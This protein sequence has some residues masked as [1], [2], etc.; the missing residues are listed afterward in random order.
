MATR[1]ELADAADRLPAFRPQR[2]LS[3]VR[4]PFLRPRAGL[5]GLPERYRLQLLLLAAERM[6]GAAPETVAAAAGKLS[7]RVRSRIPARLLAGHF[8][9]L[10]PWFRDH[11]ELIAADA[12]T[13]AASWRA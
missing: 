4:L 3:R 6:P 1:G 5:A 2:R 9:D 10:D 12:D 13:V 11:A 8:D 7:D